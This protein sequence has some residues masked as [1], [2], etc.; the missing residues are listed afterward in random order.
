MKVGLICCCQFAKLTILFPADYGDTTD[1]EDVPASATTRP[2]SLLR[3]PS[4][5]SMDK[6]SQIAS[7]AA[8]SP[9]KVPATPVRYRRGPRMGSWTVDRTKPFAM[10][11][12]TGDN[13]VIVPAKRPAPAGDFSIASTANASPVATQPTLATTIDDSE[14]DYSDFSFH[15][16]PMLASEPDVMPSTL[17]PT[18]PSSQ[19]Q[20]QTF[21]SSSVFFP[22]DDIGDVNAV[23]AMDDQDDD[24]DDDDDEELLNV[25]DFIDFGVSSEDEG[26]EDQGLLENTS[27][28]TPAST[29]PTGTGAHLQSKT[30]SPGNSSAQNL[31]KH[32]DKGVISAFCRGPTQHQAQPRRPQSGS[33]P[34]SQAFKGGRNAAAHTSLSSQKKRKL[35]DTFGGRPSFGVAAKKRLLNRR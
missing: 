22:M 23:Y 4:L 31:L 27:L 14:I 12:C 33:S 26:D 28:P 8:P 7:L 3:Q 25:E 17:F 11:D 29:S 30:P 16:D 35:S 2:Q 20:D 19:V 15:V 13:M 6:E 21:A 5:S 9:F 24:D 10:I 34:N 32:L 1:E 18:A